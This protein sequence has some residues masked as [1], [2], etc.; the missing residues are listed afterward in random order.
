M[1]DKA[2]ELIKE[3]LREYV[4]EDGASIHGAY[5]D[6]CTDIMHI[7][8]EDKEL[9]E[10]YYQCM[11]WDSVWKGLNIFREISDSACQAWREEKEE[12]E[13]EK[14]N[15]IPKKDLPLHLNDKWMFQS[16]KDALIERLEK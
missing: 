3:A 2:R 6:L 16:T 9:L 15:A 14:M 1:S 7:T 5:V 11:N 13:H 12:E 8:S 4:E 10:G